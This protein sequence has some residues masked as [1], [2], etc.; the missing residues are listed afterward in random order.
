MGVVN[1]KKIPTMVRRPRWACSNRTLHYPNLLFQQGA[2]CKPEPLGYFIVSIA[3]LVKYR[4]LD[5]LSL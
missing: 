2:S 5:D 3:L 1:S 4:N